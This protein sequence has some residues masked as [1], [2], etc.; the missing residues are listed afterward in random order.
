MSG[1]AVNGQCHAPIHASRRSPL[2]VTVGVS[3]TECG[4]GD[5][6]EGAGHG[7]SE[8]FLASE[9]AGDDLGGPWVSWI[10]R[11]KRKATEMPS[12]PVGIRRLLRWLVGHETE[13][14]KEALLAMGSGGLRDRWAVLRRSPS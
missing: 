5:D 11:I 2:N 1:W 14:M 10:T 3:A 6:K 9:A 7:S 12:W 4:R 8:V 13:M